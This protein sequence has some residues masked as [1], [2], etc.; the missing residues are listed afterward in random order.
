[1]K[2]LI[3]LALVPVIMVLCCHLTNAQS[4]RLQK[5]EAKQQAIKNLVENDSYVFEANYALP[6]SG[7]ERQ[8]TST[9][10]LRVRK[11]T[12]I[13]YLPY[14]GRAYLSPSPGETEG[15]I[16]FASTNFSYE[17]KQG[18]KGGWSIT[19]KPR[20]KN[21]TDWRDVQQ[22]TLDISADGYASLHVLSTNRDPISFEGEIMAKD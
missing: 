5:K 1:M 9:Y 13:A 14:F 18:K 15:G 11:D 20:D 12:I 4:T 8:L 10:D 16:K 6:Q 19:I 7:S 3:K 21:I 17:E 22:M 2:R